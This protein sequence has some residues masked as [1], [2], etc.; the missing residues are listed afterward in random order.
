MINVQDLLYQYDPKDTPALKKID[1]EIKK[2]SYVAIIGP[3]GCGKTTLLRHLN[4]LLVPTHGDVW[5]DGLNTKDPSSVHVIRQKVGM[6]FQNPDNQIVGMSVEEDVSFGPGNL[7]LS[8]REIRRRVDQSLEIVGMREF[9]KRHP[10]T[11]SNGEKQLISIA[12]VL[13]MDS[14][15]IAL[16]EPTTYLDPA[17]RKAVQKVI[18]QL[19]NQGI[20]IIQVT[21]NMD[22]ITEAD[23][24]IVMNEG[25]ILLSENP[26]GVFSKT[27]WLLTLGLDVPLI[28]ELMSQL[29]Q[30]GNDVRS[31]I[32]NLKDACD[33]LTSVFNRLKKTATHP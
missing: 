10:H 12:G 14:Q 15:Y 11:L 4:G 18:N 7:N 28:T 29:R 22:D 1:M 17:G 6:V 23:R 5:V 26:L 33:E 31:D 9:A 25:E 21:H 16:D 2:G 24:I 20:T 13:A 30:M 27:E 3:N 8:P 32:Y 19:N